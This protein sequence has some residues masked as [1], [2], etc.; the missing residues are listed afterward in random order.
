MLAMLAKEVRDAELGKL[1]TFRQ[2]LD[3]ETASTARATLAYLLGAQMAVAGAAGTVLAPFVFAIMDAFRDDEDLLD[4]ETEFKLAMPRMLA[5][6][7]PAGLIDTRRMSAG[8]LVPVAGDTAFAPKEGTIPEQLAFHVMKNLG[9][10]F[11]LATDYA[12]GTQALMDGDYMKFFE[13]APPKAIRDIVAGAR[14]AAGGVTDAQKVVYQDPGVWD[15][16]TRVAGLRS[17]RRAAAEQTRGAT[18]DA[19]KRISTQRDRITT[20]IALGAAL[21]DDAMVND[22]VAS[23]ERWNAAHPEHAVARQDIAGA[24]KGRVMSQVNADAFGVPLRGKPS[25]TALQ[26]AGII[27]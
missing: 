19:L 15:T 14:E 9:P 18:Y 20:R 7:L 5:Q 23:L 25:I 1:G 24:I 13:T 2:P 10:W 3:K 21:G 6:G 22:A 12:R 4:S 27:Q 11:G 17:G 26:A 16:L 8:T